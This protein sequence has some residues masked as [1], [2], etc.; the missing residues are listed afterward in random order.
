MFDNMNNNNNNFNNNFNNDIFNNNSGNNFNNDFIFQN[1][2]Q[3]MNQNEYQAPQNIFGNSFKSM[4]NEEPPV[5]PEIMN[6]NDATKIDAP[7]MDALDSG[8]F[9][10]SNDNIIGDKLDSYDM[11]N[12]NVN[13]NNNNNMLFNQNSYTM[14]EVNI[15][16]DYNNVNTNLFSNSF[17][18][19]ITNNPLEPISND[20][21]MP[22]YSTLPPLSTNDFTK[23]AEGVLPTIPNNSDMLNNLDV[24][25]NSNGLP[26]LDLTTNKINDDVVQSNNYEF[27]NEISLPNI[28]QNEMNND[29]NNDINND[30]NIIDKDYNIDNTISLSEKNSVVDNEKSPDEKSY[31]VV[32]EPSLGEEN[33]DLSNLNI[34]DMYNEPD[35]LEIMDLDIVNETSDENSSSEEENTINEVSLSDNVEKIKRLVEDMKAL[36]VK[37]ELEEF[38]FESMYQLIIKME[39]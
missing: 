6:L 3:N 32:Q 9:G 5:L 10:I 33:I 27:N 21:N 28:V 35:S 26:P 29:T 13:E 18:H 7:S 30:I 20:F 39:K 4:D 25:A 36:G 34:E 1:N 38:D 24:S 23:E 19:D 16:T 37:V 15:P 31:D 2:N 14:P 12:I 11:A 22:D 8:S 17:N